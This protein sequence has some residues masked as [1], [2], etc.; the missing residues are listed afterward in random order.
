MK[1]LR[2]DLIS[3]PLTVK[4]TARLLLVLLLAYLTCMAV[5]VDRFDWDL[6]IMLWL[7]SLP[8]ESL[9]PLPQFISR[10]GVLGV[11]G[12]LGALA[13]LFLWWGGWRSEA[14]F[15]A[16]IGLVDLANPLLRFLVGRPRP[17]PLKDPVFFLGEPQRASFPS[18][19]A[20][21]YVLFCGM[22]IYF[23]RKIL[24]SG[25]PRTALWAFLCF[26]TVFMGVWLIYNG[27]HWASDVVGG[28]LY[29][30]LYLVILIPIYKRY[31]IW[32][33]SFAVSAP[34]LSGSGTFSPL[35]T[36]VVKIVS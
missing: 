33:R 15:I 7:Q 13:I 3:M 16:M 9:S 28:Y 21:H 31:I 34:P 26:L 25:K 36:W 22:V 24:K 27:R 19:T 17:D 29:G 23:T 2:V 12:V 10:M 6:T 30:I 8:H 11:A 4:N 18:G 35:I 20:L 1:D 32:R 14:V 5:R